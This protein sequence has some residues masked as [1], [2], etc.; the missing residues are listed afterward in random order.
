MTTEKQPRRKGPEQ[1]TGWQSRM[2]QGSEES[3]KGRNEDCWPCE[4]AETIKYQQKTQNIN[5][6][7]IF[8]FSFCLQ[9]ASRSQLFSVSDSVNVDGLRLEKAILMSSSKSS[10][11]LV[12]L[13]LIALLTR[14]SLS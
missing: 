13:L 11:L 5:T 3:R 12:S 7:L 9:L 4:H 10:N 6:P 14:S 2:I 1:R 8:A